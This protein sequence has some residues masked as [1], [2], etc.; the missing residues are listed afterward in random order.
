MIKVPGIRGRLLV[1]VLALTAVPLTGTFM[2]GKNAALE[3]GVSGCR[4]DPIVYL[5]NGT[6][7]ALIVQIRD[8]PRDVKRIAYTLHVPTGA[9]VRKVVYLPGPLRG[10]ES[11]RVIDD[12]AAGGYDSDTLVSTGHNRV[13]ISVT[14]RVQGIDAVSTTGREQQTLHVHAFQP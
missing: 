3:R 4:T 10:A 11:V 12:N 8:T 13:S 1:G 5:S 14:T 9:H 7:V 6:K 2:S